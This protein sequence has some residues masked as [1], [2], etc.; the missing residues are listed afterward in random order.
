MIAESTAAVAQAPES[1]G[2]TEYINH[3]LHHLQVSVGDGSFMTLNI[4]TLFF[5]LVLS[6]LFVLYSVRET[7]G[8]E[9]EDMQA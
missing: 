5:T 4:D 6:L 9:L 3:H 1:G 2:S 7:K 8:V